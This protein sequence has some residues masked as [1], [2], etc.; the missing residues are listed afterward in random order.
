MHIFLCLYVSAI[1]IH[2]LQMNEEE[3]EDLKKKSYTHREKVW[4]VVFSSIK[5]NRNKLKIKMMFIQACHN[6]QRIRRV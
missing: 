3:D 1:K 2:Y 5:T 6:L 4:V